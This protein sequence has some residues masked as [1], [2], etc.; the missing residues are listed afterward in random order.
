MLVRN[1]S[2]DHSFFA[3]GNI[4]WSATLKNSQFLIRLNV[5]LSS[6]AVFIFLRLYTR[7]MINS[8]ENLYTNIQ[9]SFKHN[10]AV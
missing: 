8:H 7:E 2:L 5:Q 3:V 9:S 10:S 4:K 1:H 6:D